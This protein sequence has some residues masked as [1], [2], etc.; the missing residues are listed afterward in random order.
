MN[1][2]II[3]FF[4]VLAGCGA[5][6]GS[7][8]KEDSG[9]P[10]T[11]TSQVT[12]AANSYLDNQPANS[13]TTNADKYSIELKFSTDGGATFVEYPKLV[14]GQSYKVKLYHQNWGVDL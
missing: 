5:I 12:V 3:N 13:A 9:V 1:K 10:Y 11:Y 14:P 7:C 8:K 2:R 6:T 4:M